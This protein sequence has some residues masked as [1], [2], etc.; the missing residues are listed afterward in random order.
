MNL[1]TWLCFRWSK[2]KGWK[3]LGG[4]PP[5]I[6]KSIIIVAPHTS[7][8]D[9]IHGMAAYHTYGFK[10]NVYYFAK[11]SLQKIPFFKKMLGKTGY[12]PVDRSKN[13]N[14]VGAMKKRFDEADEMHL[15]IAPE[16]TRSYVK[17][18]KKGFY[19]I[20]MAVNVP[21]LL[22]YIDYE[23]KQCNISEVYHLTGD[24][25][26]DWAYFRTFYSKKQARN[27]N[28]FNAGFN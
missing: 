12:I 21:I 26:K 6:K 11:D 27:P 28:K 2:R 4:I 24:K 17:K 8:W 18:W 9:F 7:N 23:K 19:Q 22:A 15:I 20:A 1:F 13:Q 16:G 3:H 5:G 25:E 10:K 14:W